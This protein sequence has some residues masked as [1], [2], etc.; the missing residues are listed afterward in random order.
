MHKKL[1]LKIL[2]RQ[3]FDEIISEVDFC[4]CI[5]LFVFLYITCVLIDQRRTDKYKFKHFK[6]FVLRYIFYNLKIL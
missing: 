1:L 4:L 3:K 6:H 2:P 5:K